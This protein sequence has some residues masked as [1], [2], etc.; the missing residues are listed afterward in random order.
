VDSVGEKANWDSLLHVDGFDPI[1]EQWINIVM[2][3][4][5]TAID[6]WIDGLV[7]HD[8]THHMNLQSCTENAAYPNPA[9]LNTRLAGFSLQHAPLYIGGRADLSPDRHFRGTIAG[10]TIYDNS[11]QA[12][13]V[14]CNWQASENAIPLLPDSFY[15]CTDQYASNYDPAARVA[16]D[17]CLYPPPC[18]EFHEADWVDATGGDRHELGDDAHVRVELPFAFGWFAESFDFV[19]IA[20]NGFITF[21]DGDLPDVG[22]HVAGAST[23]TR[24]APD[25]TP[26]NN[27]AFAWWTDLDPSRHGGT[28]FTLS[29]S[30]HFVAEWNSPVVRHPRMSTCQLQH[31]D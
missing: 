14:G 1:T 5:P 7:D 25:P 4:S 22:T 20:S 10:A 24:R 31:T 23:Q 19:N 26:P 8:F 16:A 2:S 13:D 18:F 11:L 12:A 21:G 15:G 3:F 27:A 30:S 17:T 6:T 28:V 9:A 29:N